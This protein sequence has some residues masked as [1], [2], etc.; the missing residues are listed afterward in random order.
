MKNIALLAID[1]AKQ[2]FQLH[3]IDAE[4]KT[5]LRKK[6]SSREKF[7][8]YVA[9][10]NPC[11][12]YMEACGASNYWGRKFIGFGHDVKLINPKYV[13]PFVKRNKNDANDAEGIAAA[14]THN[15]TTAIQYFLP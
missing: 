5:V 13:K 8:L 9:N 11:N 7:T 14:A 12:I 2:V 1:L 6:I 4:G 3:G 15:Y 10:L